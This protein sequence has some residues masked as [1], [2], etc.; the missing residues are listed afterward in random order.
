MKDHVKEAL[1]KLAI[2][3]GLV[4]VTLKDISEETGINPGSFRHFTGYSFTEY[5]RIFKSQFKDQKI[6]IK[7][8]RVDKDDR[9]RGII[10]VAYQMV[11][12]K[13]FSKLKRR[14]LSRNAGVSEPLVSYYFKNMRNIKRLVLEMARQENDE[15]VIREAAIL[16]I[17]GH[18]E[19][20]KDGC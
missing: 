18:E 2:E 10:R 20:D 5:K 3:K 6:N 9:K 16:K 19:L 14:E 8:G 12:Q 11:K 13:G 1:E 17:S 15:V 7:R 4:N